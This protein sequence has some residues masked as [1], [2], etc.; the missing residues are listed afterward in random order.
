MTPSTLTDAGPNKIAPSPV[1]VICEQLPVT[2]GILSD[3]ITKI[4]APDIA[5]SVKFLLFSFTLFFN[6]I[7][8]AIRNGMQT[9]PQATQYLAG[10]YPS[11][12]CIAFAAGTMANTAAN[13]IDAFSKIFSYLDMFFPLL[14]QNP[15]IYGLI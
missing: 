3:E 13:T 12:I 15:V 7:N 11:I 9:T 10:R 5:I 14:D 1:P 2:E 8:P 4:N 6:E